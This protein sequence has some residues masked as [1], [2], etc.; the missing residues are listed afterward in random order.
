[1]V[2]IEEGA[3]C[4]WEG[5]TVVTHQDLHIAAG[6][7]LATYLPTYQP[8]YLPT[9]LPTDLSSAF[10]PGPY[11]R[12]VSAASL[13]VSTPTVFVSRPPTCLCHEHTVCASTHCPRQAWSLTSF[14]SVPQIRAQ[15]SRGGGRCR[16]AHQA[17]SQPQHAQPPAR[18]QTIARSL[19]SL[20]RGISDR[21]ESRTPP[22]PVAQ[23][24]AVEQHV[25]HP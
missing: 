20:G 13:S 15:R 25:T 18:M 7:Y 22:A 9:Y 21:V 4:K 8:T 14:R 2:F 6:T 11:G 16:R 10:L 12:C 5:V 3:S 17:L 19:S 24:A 1:M 23:I